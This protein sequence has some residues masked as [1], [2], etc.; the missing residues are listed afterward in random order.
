MY[1]KKLSISGFRGAGDRLDIPLAHR[2]LFY[3]PNGSGK[4]SL[5]QSVAW[6]LYGKIPVLSG[7]VFTREDA[8]VN[9]FMEPAAAEVVLTLS[10]DTTITRKRI[11]QT[12]TSKKTT[13]PKGHSSNAGLM[14][15]FTGRVRHPC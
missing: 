11:K 5:M 12:S 8:L 10:D 14:R 6:T 2:T 13:A 1:L 15:G 3:G 4:S 7:G 9:D